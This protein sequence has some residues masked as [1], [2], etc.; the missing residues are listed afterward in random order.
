MRYAPSSVRR[1]V[2]N[3]CW[4]APGFDSS[5]SAGAGAS[6][7]PVLH[8]VDVQLLKQRGVA[9][10]QPYLH[11]VAI[12][13]QRVRSHR[14]RIP[15]VVGREVDMIAAERRPAAAGDAEVDQRRVVA[16]RPRFLAG[17]QHVERDANPRSEAETGFLRRGWTMRALRRPCAG[18][19]APPGDD[20]ASICA[21]GI[22]SAG[23]SAT[24][25]VAAVR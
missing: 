20:S 23:Q 21:R 25:G 9:V 18:P 1:K 15:D 5:L 12:V 16:D 11:G 10:G 19:A 14:R 17:Q 8:H 13:A 3:G 6:S 4:L 24:F 7:A 22:T 2:P